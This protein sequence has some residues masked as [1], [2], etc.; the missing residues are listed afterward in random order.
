VERTGNMEHA[1][2]WK[3]GKRTSPERIVMT[4]GIPSPANQAANRRRRARVQTRF[5]ILRS[6]GRQE[7]RPTVRTW[8]W[9]DSA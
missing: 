9:A 5:R 2:R 3:R 1:R 4:L 8:A 6:G 7:S